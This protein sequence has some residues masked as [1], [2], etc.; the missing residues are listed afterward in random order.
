MFWAP[1]SV[2][3]T[4]E[5]QS[6]IRYSSTALPPTSLLSLFFLDVLLPAL[7]SKP[8]LWTDRIR[9]LK[10][11]LWG[12]GGHLWEFPPHMNWFW[13]ALRLQKVPCLSQEIWEAPS[14]H[15]W[16]W[17][18]TWWGDSQVWAKLKQRLSLCFEIF[19]LY[20]QV[21]AA[22]RQTESS[23]YS[24][25][26]C[27][28]PLNC[29]LN[30]WPTDF[31]SNVLEIRPTCLIVYR[32]FY[33]PHHCCQTEVVWFA[34]SFSWHFQDLFLPRHLTYPLALFYCHRK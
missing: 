28:G 1:H 13:P 15:Q 34:S 12:E 19:Q 3:A 10:M 23:V 33:L 29:S 16:H 4:E 7:S 8:F 9:T 2:T 14:T 18:H 25:F 24:H 11:I 31:E 26:H 5:T 21:P 22:Q 27:F 6:R 17:Q 20:A 32:S 30:H